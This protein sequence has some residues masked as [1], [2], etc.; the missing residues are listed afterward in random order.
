MSA[1]KALTQ[2]EIV[3]VRVTIQKPW[4][5]ATAEVFEQTV[6]SISFESR[7]GYS[8]SF[9]SRLGYSTEFTGKYSG[10]SGPPKAR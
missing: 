5:K 8:I 7:L 4:T 1:N 6:D 10:P 2:R 9:E 3:T